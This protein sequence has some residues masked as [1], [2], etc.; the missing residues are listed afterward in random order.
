[1]ARLLT[2]IYFPF[3]L[4]HTSIHARAYSLKSLRWGFMYLRLECSLTGETV[5]SSH[6]VSRR[7]SYSLDKEMQQERT[8]DENW[9]QEIRR[10]S[11]HISR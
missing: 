3:P 6:R 4:Q 5:R 7:R 9:L 1:M 2:A 11:I 8:I 10:A